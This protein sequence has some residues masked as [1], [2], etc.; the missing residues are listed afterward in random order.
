MIEAITEIPTP[1]GRMDAFVTHPQDGGP[2]P[3]VV[4]LMDIWGL[5]EELFDIARRVAVAGYHCTV[6]NFYYRQGPVRFEFRDEQGRMKS[7]ANISP[8]QQNSMRTQMALIKDEMAMADLRSVLKFLNTEPVKAGPK[9][10][11]GYCLGGRYALQAA[12]CYPDDFRAS[13]SLHG[14]R[15]VTDA[16]LSPHKLAAACRGE[17]YCG[18]AEHDETVPEATRKTINE[19]FAACPNVRYR[20]TLHRG[21][22]HGYAL[23]NRD[24]YDKPAANRDWEIIFAMFRRVLAA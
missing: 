2:F 19:V 3:P 15:L 10:S 12:A 16:P 6:P 21:V 22:E 7:F 18:F 4:I 8:E 13:A 11:I 5:R 24:V 20:H 17:I 1:D 9:G 14:T 23:P